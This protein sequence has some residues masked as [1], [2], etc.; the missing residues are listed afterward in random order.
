MTFIDFT[1]AG[2]YDR[3]QREPIN[4][5][6]NELIERV[7]VATPRLSRD[8]LGASSVGSECKRK[9]QFDWLCASTV[10]AKQ[11]RR[12]D[13]GHAIEATM[14]SQLE[15]VGFVFAP[16]EAL[17]FEALGYLKGHADG[18]ITGGPVL[19]TAH[20]RLPALWE[21]K[22]VYAKGWRDIVKHGLAHTYPVYASQIALYQHFLNRLNP[23]LFTAV[24]ADTCEAVHALIPFDRE[25]LERT[26]ERVS[27]IITATKEGRL[28]ERAYRDPQ[29]WHCVAQCGHRA[30]CWALP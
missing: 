15:A 8:Y 24:N 12:F 21:C 18:L 29:D 28:L 13:R 14:R 1:E 5:Q 6:L 2:Q 11:R 7:A 4:I 10:G 9:T 17:E 16:P 20:M 23:A 26:L 25:R 3:L 27:E 19:I 30:R 22:C